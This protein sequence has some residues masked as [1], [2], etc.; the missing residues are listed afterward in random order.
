MKNIF[1]AT[2]MLLSGGSFVRAQSPDCEFKPADCPHTDEIEKAMAAKPDE[3]GEFNKPELDKMTAHRAFFTQA[4][5][6][7]CERQH[8]K[9]YEFN[10]G[11]NEDV[12]VVKIDKLTDSK[13]PPTGI[14]I[15]YII[16]LD[17]ETL[18][19]WQQWNEAYKEK[20]ANT[21]DAFNQSQE[22]NQAS[23]AAEDSK[24]NDSINYYS[25]LMAQYMQAHGTQ[26][27]KDLQQNNQKGIDTYQ[28]GLDVIQKRINDFT[29]RG[30]HA[31]AARFAGLTE[32]TTKNH[33]EQKR[34]TV[35]F[36]DGATLLVRFSVNEM[37]SE[38]LNDPATGNTLKP[39]KKLAVPGSTEAYLLHNA[40]TLGNDPI[41]SDAV[42]DFGYKHPT[43][44]GFLYFGK[45]AAD[46]YE[47]GRRP[48]FRLNEANNGC[49]VEKP[50]RSDV[51]QSLSVCIE[52]REKNIR[53]FITL[54]D[55]QELAAIVGK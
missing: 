49:H 20:V 36:R 40:A 45:W 42:A 53:Q 43:D 38:F 22:K 16:I 25:N 34:E 30:S 37:V 11:R 33:D 9:W 5:Q 35:R 27:A 48:A 44:V 1:L 18:A 55:T 6:R 32:Q 7:I 26:Y 12:C 14:I 23:N 13:R 3:S 50:V 19:A 2:A 10:E 15:S 4:I 8:W 46:N 39:Q 24:T 52:G 51:A 17:K 21:M 41:R 47:Y 28:K 54:M 29:A 31:N